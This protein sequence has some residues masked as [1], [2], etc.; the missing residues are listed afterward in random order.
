ME[1]LVLQDVDKPNLMRDIFPYSQFPRMI[2]DGENVPVE[3][4][5]QIWL[6]DTTFRDGQQARAPY[7]P[8]QIL[9]VYDWLH[10]VDGGAGLIRQSE[11]F[12][13]SERD[14]RAVAL[15]R[16]R[17]Y[18][19]PEITGWIR[20]TASDLDYVTRAGITEVGVLT[21]VSDYHIFL[22]LKKNRA[23]VLQD[24]LDVIRLAL[25]RGLQ[26]R[27]HLEDV[28]RADVDGFVLPLAEAL[29]S[30]GEEAGVP[31]KM[32]LC[33]TLGL[34]VPYPEASL[35][36][37]V[38]K[39]IQRLRRLGVPSGQLEWHGHNDYHK[40]AVNGAAAWLYGCAS[41]NTTLFGMGERTGNP[42]LEAL[43]VEHA[44]LKGMS[45]RV[46]YA[47]LSELAEVVRLELGL[48][49]PANYPLVGREVNVTCAGIH[50][51]G[52][53]KHE[54]IYSDC[55]T[56]RLLQ[57]PP[58]VAITNRCGLAGIVHWIKTHLQRDVSKHDPRLVGLKHHIDDQYRYSR[59][60]TI[61]D[62]EMRSWV[63]AMFADDFKGLTPE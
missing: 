40:G 28:T 26:P 24:T 52:L 1:R 7:T 50:A 41:V 9:R 16:E 29:L 53:L 14:R 59:S 63:M 3:V 21:S 62:H 8:E 20:A 2:L 30:L 44:Q 56:G 61:S 31:I 4:P 46:N 55:D 57:R 6:T 37:S 49:I 36:R 34:G 27:C 18:D 58:T 45:A 5:E 42:P 10:A 13:Y 11:F 23:Q 43:L 32:R 33:D 51:D 60:S 48:D 19:Y 15:C 54:E 35:P 47:A 38:P 39:L 22:K 17:S 25:E 12:L